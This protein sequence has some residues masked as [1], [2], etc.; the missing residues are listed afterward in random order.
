MI[1]N[2]FA[3]ARKEFIHIIR[4][5]RTL[6]ISMLLPIILLFVYGYAASFDVKNIH[7]AVLDRSKTLHSRQLVEKLVNSGYFMKVADLN[8]EYQFREML[9][10]GK[11]TVVISIPTDFTKNLL[12]RKKTAIQVLLDG[13]DP[14]STA[15][16]LSYISVITQ[17]YFSGIMVSSATMASAGW[18]EP[19]NLALR[20]WYNPNLRS[21]NFYIPGLISSILMMLAAALTSLTIISEKENGTMEALIA[22]PVRK[23]ELMIGKILPY[24]IIAF[25]DVIL[26]TAVGKYW[27]NVPIKGSYVLMLFCSSIFLTGA[28]SIGL[29]FSTIARSSQEA[30]QLALLTTML[31]SMLLSGMIFPIENMPKVIQCVTYLV[32]ARYFL[33]IMRSIFLK[34]VDINYLLGDLIPLSIFTVLMMWLTINAFKKRLD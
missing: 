13:S 22:S 30:M 31:P 3:I 18:T 16:A 7:M 17:Q 4:D 6:A 23:N 33:R 14:T 29:L 26:I 1:K 8:G 12:S 32:P 11:A 5:P 10:S 27:F 21:L 24:I 25:W 15:A 9:D 19:V 20:I 28:L 2:V 34:G